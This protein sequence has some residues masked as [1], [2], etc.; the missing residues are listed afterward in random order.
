[1]TL[2][3]RRLFFAASLLLALCAP[4][5]AQDVLISGT[6]VD[7]S[8]GVLPGV[9][10]TAT[11]VSSGR[12]YDTLT[13]ERGEY[14]LRIGAGT[15][16]LKAELSG[17]A[18]VEHSKLEFLVGQN[19]TL[20]ITLKVA[21]LEENVT[22]MSQ[23]PLVDL[24][25]AQISGNVDPRQMEA[26][27]IAGRDWLSLSANVAGMNSNS[28]AFGKFNLQLDGQSI[29][30]ETSVTSF[31]QPG[32]S[33]DAIAEYQVITSPYDVSQGRT[34][35]LEVQAISKSGSNNLSGSAY[36]YFRDDAFNTVDPF[37]D[38]VLP[39]AQQQYGGTF[40]GPIVQNKTHYF[41]AYERERNPNTLNVHPSALAPQQVNIPTNDDKYNFLIRG[42]HQ[43]SNRDH[44]VVRG[45]Y[46]NRLIPNDGIASHP[47]RGAKKDTTSY[48]ITGNWTH[49]SESGLM[50]EVRVGYFRYYW[51]WGAA[52][53]LVLTP[54]YQFPGLTMGLNW[55]YPEFIRQARL[56]IRYDATSHKGN[57]DV[58]IGGEFNNGLD[59]GDW[60]ARERGQYFFTVLPADAN[61]RFPLDKDANS[62]DFTGLDSTVIRFDRTYSND[63]KYNIPRKT[64]AA[65]IAD[66]WTLSPRLTLNLG[67]RYDLSWGDYAPPNVQET[68]LV[69]NNGLFTEDVGYRNDIRDLNNL[70]PRVGFVWNVTDKSDLVIRGGTGVFYSGIGGN[71]AFDQQLWNAQR[72]IFNSYANDGKPGFLADPTRGA[73]ADDILNGRVPKSPQAVSV[74]DPNV[75]TPRSW[76]TSLGFQKQL[77][78]VSAIEADLVY[79]EGYHE[80]TVRDPNAFY[81]P[82]TGWPRNPSQGRPRTDYGPI[83]LIGTD[84]WSES[85]T[86]PVTFTRR[87]SNNFQG[88]VIYAYVFFDRNAGIGGSGYGNDLYNPFDA[89]YNRRDSGI[90]HHKVR[91]NGLWNVGM[92]FNVSGVWQFLSGDYSSFTSGLNP[93]GGYGNNRLRADLS[94]VPLNTF[95]NEAN[96]QLDLRVAKDFRLRGTAK[97]TLSAEVFNI[98]K[99]EINSY[100]LRENSRTFMQ[101][102]SIR[103]I[104]GR[105]PIRSGQLAFRVSF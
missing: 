26:I 3:L 21:S 52:D 44:L 69:I 14:R 98:Y 5:T 10:V 12:S 95:K 38:T 97:V 42:D 71:P 92:G 68:S 102:T 83:R 85:L 79:L 17:F 82:A 45:N 31:G 16:N 104:S 53:G 32:I 78:T 65:W 76:R 49:A 100:D 50:Q 84:G 81:N 22:V 8:K 77:N 48:S 1:M 30:Q 103:S 94:F 18:V 90:D 15:Y 4:A 33:R 62:W 47:S 24:R 37:T 57:H 67:I 54:E 101:V 46:S 41:G 43:F 91:F 7:E 87:Y 55:N 86:L 63:W 19:A 13:D 75:N 35:G 58:K 61:R 2:M 27:P 40:G 51:H 23:S 9:T 93:L 25:S 73:S 88:S 105:D 66:T 56:P 11:D 72:V 99:D 60:P 36:G 20:P 70:G 96:S 28:F 29:T 89:S 59:D 80:E 6:V 64:Y 39:F 74:I 34:V